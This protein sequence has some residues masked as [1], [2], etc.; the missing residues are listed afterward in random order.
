MKPR[1]PA[2]G[3]LVAA[4][5]ACAAWLAACAFHPHGFEEMPADG[6]GIGPDGAPGPDGGADAA[7]QDPPDLARAYPAPKGSIVLDGALDDWAAARWYGFSYETAGLAE[8]VPDYIPSFV[9]AFAAFY[10][11]SN[12]WLAFQVSDDR[13]IYDS[14]NMGDDDAV[15]LYLDAAG[16]HAGPYGPDDYLLVA[17]AQAPFAQCGQYTGV[18]A[19]SIECAASLQT[20]SYIIEL[21]IPLGGISGVS[22]APA[23]G[24][25]IGFNVGIADDDDLPNPDGGSSNDNE[26]DASAWW[27]HNPSTCPACC[28]G[29]PQRSWCDTSLFGRLAFTP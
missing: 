11:E 24:S 21:R 6:G 22:P 2:V 5:A 9:A 20:T 4:A 18:P 19:L 14:N 29:P 12:L 3:G 7:G 1:P 23:A 8:S 25:T 15:A 27:I 17:I 10:D 13:I 28:G 26:N 16:D